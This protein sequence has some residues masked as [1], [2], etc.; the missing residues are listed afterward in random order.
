VE[1][2][3]GFDYTT[4]NS[5]NLEVECTDDHGAVS[6]PGLFTI[7]LKKNEAPIIHNLQGIIRRSRVMKYK[8]SC[9]NSSQMVHKLN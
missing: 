8:I 3:P 1:T 6:D 2:S 5:Y 4:K 9:V 7:Y